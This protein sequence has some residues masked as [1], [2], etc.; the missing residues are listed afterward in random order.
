MSERILYLDRPAFWTEFRDPECWL[1][2]LRTLTALQQREGGIH[3]GSDQVWEQHLKRDLSRRA[4]GGMWG[5]RQGGKRPLL[6]GVGFLQ[7]DGKAWRVSEEAAVFATSYDPDQATAGFRQLAVSLMKSS[8][9][10]R[11]MILRLQR[12]EWEL[13]NWSKVRGNAEKFA[14]GKNLIFHSHDTPDT[15]FAGIEIACLGSWKDKLGVDRVAVDPDVMARKADSDQF[16]WTP[17]KSPLYLL[18][19]LGWLSDEGV[20]DIPDQVLA[21]AGLVG[22]HETST[23]PTSILRDYTAR[24]ADLRGFVPIEF[25]LRRI[26]KRDAADIDDFSAW[27]DTVMQ[28]AID[29]GSIEILAAEPGQSRHGRGLSGDRQRKLVRW[30]IH[31]DFNECLAGIERSKLQSSNGAHDPEHITSRSEGDTNDR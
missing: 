13:A 18:D 7:R 17:L 21:D 19:F 12:G 25:A 10:L 23:D 11:L 29:R 27:M 14:V 2:A 31:D 4:M 6:M 8:P 15:W 1:R 30:V 5:M 22:E 28:A 20:P 16:A 9:W 26:Y 3:G 24:E